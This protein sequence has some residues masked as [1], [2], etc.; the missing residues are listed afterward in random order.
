MEHVIPKG[1]AQKKVAQSVAIVH[2]GNLNYLLLLLL[3]IYNNG[4]QRGQS[5]RGLDKEAWLK[6]PETKGPR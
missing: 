6:G 4:S 2:Q 1:N 3:Q 5:Q